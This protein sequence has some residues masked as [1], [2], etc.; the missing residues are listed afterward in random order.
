MGHLIA[1]FCNVH[2]SV[3]IHGRDIIYGK[4]WYQRLIVPFVRKYDVVVC[5]SRATLSECMG[6]GV[7]AEQC[8]VVPCGVEL[9]ENRRG[10]SREE[11]VAMLESAL[12]VRLSGSTVI[13]TLGRLVRRKGVAWFV[14]NVMPILPGNC[15]YL[16]AGDGPDR[17]RVTRMIERR[18]LTSR[19]HVLGR[20]GD[21]LRDALYDA[22]DVFVAPNIP[23]ERDME[24]FG[25][26]LLEAGARDVPVVAG[27]IDG[28]PDAV[29]DGVT[30]RLVEPESPEAFAGAI[31]E[32][33][34]WD[35]GA[36]RIR[37]AVGAKYGWDRVYALYAEALGITEA[38]AHDSLERQS[39]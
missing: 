39:A 7:I 6:R 35:K 12:N 15:V 9:G 11:A 21:T 17:G 20:I 14:E 2:L 19:V 22:T 26:V 37:A 28:I 10:R 16:A 24:G 8:R 18:G 30:G 3:A 13:T 23:V 29:V 33:L 25:I 38:V 31:A 4:G 34:A 32:V 5:N 1:A 27:A 36:G